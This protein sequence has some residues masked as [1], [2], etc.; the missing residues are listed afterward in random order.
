MPW[1]GSKPEA[2]QLLPPLLFPSPRDS[3]PAARGSPG[4]GKP[5]FSHKPVASPFPGRDRADPVSARGATLAAPARLSLSSCL[6]ALQWVCAGPRRHH[7]QECGS[8]WA[9]MKTSWEGAPWPGRGMRGDAGSARAS[10]PGGGARHAEPAPGARQG[11]AAVNAGCKVAVSLRPQVS[12][13]GGQPATG[14]LSCSGT[15]SASRQ[16]AVES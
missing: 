13:A 16:S 8:A 14:S 1:L 10:V 7:H 11:P 5:A 15:G 3:E 2:L 4:E 6:F 9:A 12:R